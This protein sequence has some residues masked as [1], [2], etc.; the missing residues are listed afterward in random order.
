MWRSILAVAAGLVAWTMVVSLINLGLEHWLAGYRAA[1]PT[2]VFTLPMKIAR[3]VM[4]AV[5]SVAAGVVVR[6]VAPQSRVAPWITGLIVLALFLPSH[7]YLFHR[8]PLWYHLSFLV[9]LV[10]LVVLGAALAPKRTHIVPEQTAAA[11]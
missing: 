5:T 4:A 11:A 1:E 9:P 10:P 7:I 6:L 3:L 8:F 2:L